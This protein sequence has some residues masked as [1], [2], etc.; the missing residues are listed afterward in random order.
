MSPGI[1]DC[2][3]SCGKRPGWRAGRASTCSALRLELLLALGRRVRQA[4][5][6]V[7]V[8]RA[9]G[10]G[11][12]LAA[13]AL[14]GSQTLLSHGTGG[15][16]HLCRRQCLIS[17]SMRL[18]KALQCTCTAERVNAPC[19]P[20]GSRRPHVVPLPPARPRTRASTSSSRSFQYPA[21]SRAASRQSHTWQR[22]HHTRTRSALDH[23]TQMLA[24]IA[25]LLIQ[26]HFRC[27]ALPGGLPRHAR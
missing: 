25:A 16:G 20:S 14:R 18:S 5:P 4:L 11:A 27:L 9:L 15:S 12:R 7:R 10:G 23:L 22:C 13:H 6:P 24:L 17:A 19:L 21:C 1:A 3:E 26:V 2:L 8:P